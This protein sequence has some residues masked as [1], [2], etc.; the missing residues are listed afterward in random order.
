MTTSLGAT[1]LRNRIPASSTVVVLGDGDGINLVDAIATLRTEGYQIVLS[2]GGPTVIGGLFQAGVLN[3]IFLTL[4][5]ILAG[6][7]DAGNRPGLVQGAELLP[8]RSISGDLLSVRKD[9]SHL[10]LRYAAR[11][12]PTVNELAK[13]SFTPAN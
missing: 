10:F 8:S 13:P 4:S 12:G 3:E 6:R 11:Y 2:E 9:G 7:S 5:P 1:R